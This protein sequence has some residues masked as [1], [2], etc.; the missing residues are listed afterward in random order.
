MNSGDG[1]KT[2]EGA[3]KIQLIGYNDLSNQTLSAQY[4]QQL[5][6]EDQVDYLLGP[7]KCSV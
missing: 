5:I 7:C 4:Y 6:Q 1:I 2:A 3:Y